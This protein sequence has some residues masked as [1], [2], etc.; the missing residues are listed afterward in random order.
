[1]N[2][3][4]D[5]TKLGTLLCAF[6]AVAYTGYN[7]CFDY[8][9]KRCDPSWINCVQALVSVVVVGAYLLWLAA[10]GRPSLPSPKELLALVIIGLITAIGGVL[11][12]WS[13][14]V[15][16]AAVA[17]TLQTGIMLA[18][19]AGLGLLLLKERVSGLQVM[20]IAIITIAA[21][22]ITLGAEDTSVVTTATTAIQDRTT[23]LGLL[24]SVRVLLGIV[25][26]GSAGIAFAMLTVGVRKS[27]TGDTLPEAVVF[28]I[29]VTGL[30]SLGAWS[31]CSLGV[32]ELM[33]T[34]PGDLAVMLAAGA[35]NL[36]AFFLVTK[37]LQ[38]I[39]VVRL[40][41][42]NNGLSTAL[43][44]VAGTLF[45]NG[46]WN[47]LLALGMFLAIIG[48]L[49]I[50]MEAPVEEAPVGKTPEEVSAA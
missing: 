46:P 31:I 49:L 11:F 19:G 14:S 40:N 50:S 6:S 22:V 33:Q 16:G 44:A 8:V 45:F 43:T 27:V 2:T 30:V 23:T 5:L 41:V 7:L 17:V 36:V 35:L 47:G 29:S 10:H 28:L 13:M 37:S 1:M 21:V 48:I 42:L 34:S 20:A 12:V 15:V 32:D 4:R 26:A 9:S 24:P 3:S 38:M 25:A 18:A 39:T